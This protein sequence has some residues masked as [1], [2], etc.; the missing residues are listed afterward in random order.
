MGTALGFHR[1]QDFIPDD[2]DVDVGILADYE[3]NR[4]T[5]RLSDALRQVLRFE[6]VTTSF[7]HARP[8]Q[9]AFIDPDNHCIFDIYF[10]YVNFEPAKIVNINCFGFMRYPAKL[11]EEPLTKLKNKHGTWPALAETEAY[12]EYHY[13]DTWKEPRPG[14]KGIYYD[15]TPE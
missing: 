7:Y 10:Y 8:M 4:N 5:Q 2:T 11:F 15:G 12:L 13:G 1:D 3:L 9:L 14:D 6:P